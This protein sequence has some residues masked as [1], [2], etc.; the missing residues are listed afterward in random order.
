MRLEI[1]KNYNSTYITPSLR[2]MHDT[3]FEGGLSRLSIEIVWL[4]WSIDLVII[5]R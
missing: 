4:R 1:S 2:I 5:D 3:F